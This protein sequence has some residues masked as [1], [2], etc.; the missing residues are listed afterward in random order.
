MDLTVLVA[1]ATS[2]STC[3]LTPR[4]V[5]L[6]SSLSESGHRITTHFST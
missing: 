4:A 1:I 3:A 5:G 6:P 2:V